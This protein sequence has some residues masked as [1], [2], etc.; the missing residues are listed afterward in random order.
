MCFLSLHLVCRDTWQRAHWHTA[1]L[2]VLPGIDIVFALYS[3]LR[4]G[5]FASK[6]QLLSLLGQ[7]CKQHVVTE[8]RGGAGRYEYKAC[9][10]YTC[11]SSSSD[12]STSL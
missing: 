8:Q 2:P 11:S 5:C 3:L 1:V 7:T 4:H 12:Y 6:A 10:R 9:K